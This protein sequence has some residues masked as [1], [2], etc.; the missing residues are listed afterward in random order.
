MND[1][2]VVNGLKV[3]KNH[4]KFLEEQAMTGIYHEAGSISSRNSGV[5][6]VRLAIHDL[7]KFLK[8]P[9]GDYFYV[10]PFGRHW[11]KEN[12]DEAMR[13]LRRFKDDHE[14]LSFY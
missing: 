8:N 10:D 9:S 13:L 7:K 5:A 4:L 3:L 6:Q 12:L 14:R 2:N 11:S 1:E